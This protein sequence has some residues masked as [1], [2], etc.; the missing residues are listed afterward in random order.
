M[1]SR[2]D[3]IPREIVN[4]FLSYQEAGKELEK[5]GGFW[6]GPDM[7][8]AEK[9]II[10]KKTSQVAYLS[11]SREDFPPGELNWSIFR[12]L[13]F[14]T[15]SRFAQAGLEIIFRPDS[16]SE[17]DME[18][19]NNGEKIDVPVVI[20]NQGTRPVEVEGGV[21]RFFWVNENNRLSGEELK[22]AVASQ[23]EIE[24]EQGKDWF[25][26][27][28]NFESEETMKQDDKHEPVCRSS[29]PQRELAIVF[30]IRKKLRI[31][32]S[33]EPLKI[34]SRKALEDALVST[35]ENADPE[36]VEIGETPKVKLSEDLY[37][38]INPGVSD[39]GGM[40]RNSRLIDPGFSGAIRTEMIYGDKSLE[41]FVYKKDK[42]I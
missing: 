26:S 20:N 33:D 12:C 2:R 24:G 27:N 36:T 3:G 22:S 39:T 13:Q 42:K 8:I 23:M 16:F 35:E 4:E 1:E 17:G 31:P 21:V 25:Y 29:G 5:L 19:I 40:H 28:S 41:L 37:A 18:R 38:V 34:G 30:P 11:V 32:E 6:S 10:D 9:Q 15:R 14:S 7:E